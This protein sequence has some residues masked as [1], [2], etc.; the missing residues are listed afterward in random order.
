M[1]CDFIVINLELVEIV[2]IYYEFLE[3][4]RTELIMPGQVEVIKK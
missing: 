3:T 1:G 4:W 2:G